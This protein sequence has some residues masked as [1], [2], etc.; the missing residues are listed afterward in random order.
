M[1]ALV[2]ADNTLI[3]PVPFGSA[4]LGIGIVCA[5]VSLILIGWMMIYYRTSIPPKE[6]SPTVKRLTLE[7]E[8]YR[9]YQQALDELTVSFMN[10]SM[11]FQ[12]VHTAW[13][14]I[15]RAAASLASGRHIEVA[16]VGDIRASFPGWPQLA[17]AIETCEDVTFSQDED[18]TVDDDI[19]KRHLAQVAS[20]LHQLHPGPRW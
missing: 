15:L 10:G 14:A 11:S 19:F 5:I 13:S 9:K 3:P 2:P 17:K 4:T 16:T 20:V 12:Q 8:A 7:E 1:S 6:I 18:V